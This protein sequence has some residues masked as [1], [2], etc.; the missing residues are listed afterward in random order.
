MGRAVRAVAAPHNNTAENFVV[1][2]K[3][4]LDFRAAIRADCIDEI[5]CVEMNSGK[6][7]P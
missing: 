6:C 1:R 4:V 7:P 3:I 5:N 2:A